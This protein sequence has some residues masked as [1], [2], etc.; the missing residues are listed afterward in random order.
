M[1]SILSGSSSKRSGEKKKK[2]KKGKK[3]ELY[4]METSP[5]VNQ[6]LVQNNNE[7]NSLDRNMIKTYENWNKQIDQQQMTNFNDPPGAPVTYSTNYPN[8]Q[9]DLMNQSWSSHHDVNN[10]YYQMT[11]PSNMSYDPNQYIHAQMP[12]TSISQVQQV[13]PEERSSKQVQFSRPTQQGALPN[14]LS[15]NTQSRYDQ[16]I[17]T[18][19]LSVSIPRQDISLNKQPMQRSHLPTSNTSLTQTTVEKPIYVGIDH[20]ATLAERGQKTANKRQRKDNDKNNSEQI[21]SS[22]S[23][24]KTRS[25]THHQ[26]KYPESNDLSTSQVNTQS[27][28][29]VQPLQAKLS[30]THRSLTTTSTSTVIP[31][32]SIQNNE[33]SIFNENDVQVSKKRRNRQ[34]QLQHLEQQSYVDND[35]KQSRNKRNH[36]QEKQQSYVSN[37]QNNSPLIT[38]PTRRNENKYNS[39]PVIKAPLSP[40]RPQQRQRSSAMPSTGSTTT[41]V[42]RTRV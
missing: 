11:T 20:K 39:A 10:Q 1:G 30:G 18:N 33:Q 8:I 38:E 6:Y 19:D 17:T 16:S 26:H 31:N 5:K 37:N 36:G 4:Q 2:W 32:K 13:I 7:Q 15:T 25:H 42:T 9:N 40:K 24:H 21:N 22:T 23:N 3:K 34:S 14:N 35:T 27:N 12:S 28:K 41:N 29:T